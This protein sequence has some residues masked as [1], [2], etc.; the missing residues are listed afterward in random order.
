MLQRMLDEPIHYD[1]SQCM[2]AHMYHEMHEIT[3]QGAKSM[4]AEV[5]VLQVWAWEYLPVLRPV[6][7]DMRQPQQPYIY[8]YRGQMTQHVLGKIEHFRG[9]IDDLISLIWRL[10]RETEPWAEAS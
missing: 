9:Q 6:F 5:F 8:Q 7:E 3:Y 2:L 4:A 1:W 10:W